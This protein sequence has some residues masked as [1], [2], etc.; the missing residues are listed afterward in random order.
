MYCYVQ[1]AESSKTFYQVMLCDECGREKWARRGGSLLKTSDRFELSADLR[2]PR[3]EN[4]HICTECWLKLSH[5]GALPERFA[6]LSDAV[7]EGTEG[8]GVR[9]MMHATFMCNLGGPDEYTNNWTH[10]DPD[11]L[12]QLY[13]CSCH[14]KP[15]KV[16]QVINWT[17]KLR[18]LY[19]PAL[20]TDTSSD[21]DE[22]EIESEAQS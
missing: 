5:M 11:T 2:Y 15:M 20:E 12:A 8:L 9:K 18:P 22:D 14:H 19:M 7:A 6:R 3:S 13:Y 4:R 10:Q 21:E 16:K 1:K 17:E